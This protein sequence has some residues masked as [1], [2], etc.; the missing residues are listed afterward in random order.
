MEFIV[1]VLSSIV[2]TI[3]VAVSIMLW[4]KLSVLRL[5][6][7]EL[8]RE[9]EIMERFK[10]PGPE[11][12]GQWFL[13]SEYKEQKIELPIILKQTGRIVSGRWKEMNRA[14]IIKG[15]VIDGNLVAY[16]WTENTSGNA[17]TGTSTF[18]LRPDGRGIEGMWS[19][20]DNSAAIISSGRASLNRTSNKSL[21]ATAASAAPQL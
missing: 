16:Y 13:E 5:R 7:A 10:A 8:L 21:E 4:R 2:A 17:T 6:L 3:L 12:S 18:R 1:S 20:Y 9:Q 19:Q 14:G 15:F 11:L